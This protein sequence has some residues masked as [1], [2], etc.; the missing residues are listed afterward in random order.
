MARVHVRE[1]FLFRI[2]PA[3]IATV[4]VGAVVNV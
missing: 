4:A 1:S 3:V 2:P